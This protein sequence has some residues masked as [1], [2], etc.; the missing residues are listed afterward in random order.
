[1]RLGTKFQDKQT[2]SIFRTKFAEKGT[3]DQKQKKELS[4][5]HS[6][7]IL[8]KISLDLWTKFAQKGRKMTKLEI[9]F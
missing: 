3:S 8:K 2:I 7:Y 6:A 4:P 9:L 1:M 5:P